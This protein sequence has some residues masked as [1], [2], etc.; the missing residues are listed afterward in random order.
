MRSTIITF[1]LA[2]MS[3]W[4]GALIALTAKGAITAE[5]TGLGALPVIAGLI[6]MVYKSK[7]S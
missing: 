3:V 4:V 5:E 2:L 7:E 6:V 1:A